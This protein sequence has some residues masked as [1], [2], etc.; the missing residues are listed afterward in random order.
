MKYRLVSVAV[1][2]QSKLVLTFTWLTYSAFI[3]GPTY[4]LL[5]ELS[6]QYDHIEI[7]SHL[8]ELS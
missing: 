3:K 6:E 5:H 2:V 8:L 4:N 7:G 1:I